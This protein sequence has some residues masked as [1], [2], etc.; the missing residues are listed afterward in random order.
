MNQIDST[1]HVGWASTDITPDKPVVI[2]GQFHARVSEG[3]LDPITA[4]ALAL[5]STD[6]DGPANQC[7]MVSCDLAVIADN[8]RDQVRAI[9][10]EQ[11][12]QLDPL[13]IMFNATHTHEAPEIRTDTL[14]GAGH[15]I[16]GLDVMSADQTSEMMSHRIA[17]AIVE[18][19]NNR[20]P[21]GM[22]FGLG[23]AS[24][25]FNRRICFYSG[26]T[27]MYGGVS[28]PDFSHVEGGDDT[29]VN[30]MGFYTPEGKLT[31]VIINVAC[32]SQVDENIFQISADY[33]HE[34]RLTLRKQLGDDIFILPQCSAAGDLVP[35]RPT[36]VPD[37]RAM[38]RM[39]ELQGISKRQDIANRLTDAVAG[40]LNVISN[41]ID[42]QPALEHQAATIEVSRRM[43]S[44]EDVDQAVATAEE[45][46]PIYEELVA[47]IKADPS[48]REQPRWYVDV[49]RAYRRILWNMRVAERFEKQKTQ[50]KLPIEVHIIRLG[51][52]AF[53]SNP[54]E[55][56]RDFGHQI[57]AG[58]PAVQTFVVQ[59]A[60]EGTYLPTERAASA[61]SYGA[62]PAS[63]PVGPEG[64][65]ELALWSI[66]ALRALWPQ[67]QP[68][69]V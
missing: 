2:A 50:P 64:G 67:E 45:F 10:T 25:G 42:Y 46:R 44:Q 16:D 43:L 11:L 55:Y 13:S 47:K 53:A 26:E 63:T 34:L 3:V 58:S 36:S 52:A 1:L 12:P 59:L 39:W 5:E 19:W 38:E 66:E 9:V 65:R 22:A 54:F 51:D 49:T 48:I 20:Q 18:A 31:G 30:V 69:A 40:V 15:G 21:G 56:Y 35:P 33:W 68:A 37:Y 41:H 60:G 27:R 61:G 17:N 24:L 4:T 23:H 32:P 57:K 6:S 62:L 14:V 7:V 28:K 8:L 29:S